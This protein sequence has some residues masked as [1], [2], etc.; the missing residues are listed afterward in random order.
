MD[1]ES[2]GVVGEVLDLN[3]L[4]LGF[5]EHEV[6]ALAYDSVLDFAFTGEVLDWWRMDPSLLQQSVSWTIN[7]I[8]EPTFAYLFAIMTIGMLVR[9]RYKVVRQPL[10]DTKLR[11][12]RG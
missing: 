8:P 12:A 4:N 1:G 3:A 9:R 5:G 11:E 10:A 2:V 7:T 6:M